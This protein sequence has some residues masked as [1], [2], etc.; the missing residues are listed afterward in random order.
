[1]SNPKIINQAHA[2]ALARQAGKEKE[3]TTLLNR[4][5]H[6]MDTETKLKVGKYFISEEMNKKEED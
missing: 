5:I 4:L 2:Y 3:A 6:M 1:V